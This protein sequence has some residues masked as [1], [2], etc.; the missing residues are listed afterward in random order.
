MDAVVVMTAE[1]NTLE[2]PCNQQLRL[3]AQPAD[4]NL[5]LVEIFVV[6]IVF[7][8]CAESDAEYT[9][10]NDAHVTLSLT[11]DTMPLNICSTDTLKNTH[12]RT[13]TLKEVSMNDFISVLLFRLA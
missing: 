3:Y 2:R 6:E 9:T 10:A 8:R 12:H 11:D 4:C 7:E 5:L 13:L 1:L